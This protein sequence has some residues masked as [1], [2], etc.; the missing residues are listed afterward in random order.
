MD[1]IQDVYY[2][3]VLIYRWQGFLMQF[4]YGMWL[5][6]QISMCDCVADMP[7]FQLSSIDI[8]DR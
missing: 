8:S 6:I 7:L 2:V 3:K 4:R 5:G 1:K